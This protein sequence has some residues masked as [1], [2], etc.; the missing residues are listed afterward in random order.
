MGWFRR[1]NR[2]SLGGAC[3]VCIVYS[4]SNIAD[5]FT[6]PNRLVGLVTHTPRDP[7]PDATNDQHGMEIYSIHSSLSV[8]DSGRVVAEAYHESQ[9]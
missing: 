4:A 8:Q 7:R 3:D 1:L 2:E 6:A 5:C 9:G